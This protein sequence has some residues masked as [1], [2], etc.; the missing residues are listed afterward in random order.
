MFI[1]NK[2]LQEPCQYSSSIYGSVNPCIFKK[3]NISLFFYVMDK[4][5]KITDKIQKNNYLQ[6]WQNFFKNISNLILYFLFY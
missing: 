3:L 2:C 4:L 6:A 1:Q 5:L